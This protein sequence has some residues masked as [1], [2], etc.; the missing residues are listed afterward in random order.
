MRYSM[1]AV[2]SAALLALAGMQPAAAADCGRVTIADMNWASAEFA[3]HVDKIILE[4]GY[5]CE[6]EIVPG[7]T[8]P[9]ST[10]MVEKGEP[11]IA[12]EIWPNSV[13]KQIDDAVAEGRLHY[14]V[15]ILKDGGQEGWW[16]PQYV[17]DANPEIETVEDALARP[18]LFTI[19]NCRTRARCTVAHPVGTA[20]S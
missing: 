15:E 19:P 16:I 5:G 12:P 20:R 17:K 11:D 4:Q 1:T 18:D 6:V 13:K 10:S 2:A 7:D 8:M 14:V 9:T 3:A